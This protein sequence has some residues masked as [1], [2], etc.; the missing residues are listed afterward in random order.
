MLMMD[1]HME[2]HDRLP[3]VTMISCCM[4]EVMVLPWVHLLMKQCSKVVELVLR[5]ISKNEKSVRIASAES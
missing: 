3:S 2:L 4:Q 5:T 1:F